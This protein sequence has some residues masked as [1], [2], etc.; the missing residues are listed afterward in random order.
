M[1]KALLAC[2][3]AFFIASATNAGPVTGL[4]FFGHRTNVIG[5]D[6]LFGELVTKGAIREFHR[7]DYRSGFFVDMTCVLFV[8]D[9]TTEEIYTRLERDAGIYS[10]KRVSQCNEW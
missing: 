3:A 5:Q 4:S 10:L 8:D 6:D 2:G 1:K 9:K 7:V